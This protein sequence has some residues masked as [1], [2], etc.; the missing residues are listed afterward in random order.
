MLIIVTKNTKNAAGQLW[1][2]KCAGEEGISRR[3]IWGYFDDRPATL[4]NELDNVRIVNWTW[5][6]ISNWLDSL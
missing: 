2:V 5:T 4:P 6:N 1:E 3:G